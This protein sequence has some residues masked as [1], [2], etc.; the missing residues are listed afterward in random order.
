MLIGLWKTMKV[1]IVLIPEH[2]K[3]V[4]GFSRVR[5]ETNIAGNLMY[6]MSNSVI[7]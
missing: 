4:L 6:I 1:D 3:P 5:L 2:M 7:A